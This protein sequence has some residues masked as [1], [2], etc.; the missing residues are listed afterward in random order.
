MTTVKIYAIIGFLS[1]AFCANGQIVL[2]VEYSQSLEQPLLARKG[3]TVYLNADS[4]WLVNDG[5]LTFYNELH[6]A[7]QSGAGEW[8]ELERAYA[9]ALESSDNAVDD[10]HQNFGSMSG[11]INEILTRQSEMFEQ[12]SFKLRYLEQLSHDQLQQIALLKAT[13]KTDKKKRF[14]RSVK[15]VAIGTVIGGGA[16]A[17]YFT[18]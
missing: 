15:N 18:R 6:T 12:Q 8:L 10:L 4:I 2:P 1:W 11:R 7:F 16:A 9:E 3:Q 17:Y 13:L 5:R 14:W